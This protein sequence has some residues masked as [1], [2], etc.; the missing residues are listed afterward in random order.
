MNKELCELY[1]RKGTRITSLLKRLTVGKLPIW[2]SNNNLTF[3]YISG[4]SDQEIWMQWQL[5]RCACGMR[6]VCTLKPTMEHNSILHN[7]SW[8]FLYWI[9][10]DAVIVN[11]LLL[12]PKTAK[13]TPYLVITVYPASEDCKWIKLFPGKMLICKEIL[14]RM[15][16]WNR[17]CDIIELNPFQIALLLLLVKCA[18]FHL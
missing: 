7:S 18:I 16:P 3:L 5:F 11:G 6:A 10:Q 14:F 13:K 4:E 12:Q 15:L 17:F 2:S 8:D 1:P 9:S